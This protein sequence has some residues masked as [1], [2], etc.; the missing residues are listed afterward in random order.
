MQSLSLPL[1]VSKTGKKR[2]L[3]EILLQ[4]SSDRDCVPFGIAQASFYFAYLI[5]S[6]SDTLAKDARVREE[7]RMCSQAK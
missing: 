6:R 2:E 3:N 1:S 7:K 5:D 4:E